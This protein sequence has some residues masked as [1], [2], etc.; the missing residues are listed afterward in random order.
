MCMVVCVREKRRGFLTVIDICI[1]RAEV[2][3]GHL[4]RHEHERRSQQGPCWVI[5]K[6]VSMAEQKV[7]LSSRNSITIVSVTVIG[8][9]FSS[10]FLP[11][12]LV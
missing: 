4:G 12:F 7:T 3:V 2:Y 6:A 10:F 8:S 1:T 5:Y 11:F 9:M